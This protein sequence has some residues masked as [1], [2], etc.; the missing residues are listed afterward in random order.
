[1]LFKIKQTAC[2]NQIIPVEFKKSV[3]YKNTTLY[4]EVY[5]PSFYSFKYFQIGI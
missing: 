3:Y 4:I 2:K 1:M 5:Q